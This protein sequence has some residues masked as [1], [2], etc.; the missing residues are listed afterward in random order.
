MHTYTHTYTHAH[1]HTHTCVSRLVNF[2]TV[3]HR[4]LRA[5]FVCLHATLFR[6]PQNTKKGLCKN[7]CIALV[8]DYRTKASTQHLFINLKILKYI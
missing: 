1:T 8:L 3:V 7:M 5:R 6:N 4:R 2:I